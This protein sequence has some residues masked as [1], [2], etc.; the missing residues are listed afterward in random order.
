MTSLQIPSKTEL[1]KQLKDIGLSKT[2]INDVLPSWWENGVF[3]TKIGVLEFCLTIKSRLGVSISPNEEGQIVLARDYGRIEF[4]KRAN[5]EV[6]KLNAAASVAQGLASI[7]SLSLE[8]QQKFTDISKVATQLKDSN[9]IKLEDVVDICWTNNLPVLFLDNMPVNTP[10]PAGM[11]VKVRKQ[12]C[13]LLAH[14]D[15]SDAAQSFVLLHEL[16]HI[17][18]GH[19]E[20]KD[21]YIDVSMA[22][23]SDSLLQEYDSQEDA[24]DSFALNILRRE[25]DV[26]SFFK[27]L[28]LRP[29]IAQLAAASTKFGLATGIAPGHLALSYG[30]ETNDWATARKALRFLE[31]E[32]DA[33]STILNKY[34]QYIHTLQLSEE[35]SIF[36]RKFQGIDS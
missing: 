19:L 34:C 9:A 30:K 33:K 29:S 31:P 13:I 22:E 5:V 28:P 8:F 24:A 17:Y 23:L 10:K 32:S 18:N 3:D 35:D 12:Y 21:I 14:K 7:I 6:A 16:G 4:K 2:L 11:V 20:K 36:L 15:K 25:H 26:S 27:H 1:F